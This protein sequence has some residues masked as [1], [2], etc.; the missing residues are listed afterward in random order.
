MKSLLLLIVALTWLAIFSN[1][2]SACQCR[3]YDVP[4]C[5]AYWT[6]STVFVGQL[7][8]ITLPASPKSR[9]DWP[10]ATLH[11]IVEQPFRGVK[12]P[13][14]DV[15]TSYGAMCDHKFVKGTRYLVYADEDSTS[16]KLYTGF[17]DRTRELDDASDDISYIRSVMQQSATESIVGI[18]THWKY[19][20]FAGVK[21]EVRNDSKTLEA[22]TD[23]KGNFWISPDGPG[24]FTCESW[25]RL[26]SW[27][28]RLPMIPSKLSNPRMS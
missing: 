7:R 28:C 8:D 14:V 17:C 11:F 9:E 13:T 15:E 27:L 16:H 3:D 18:V 5:A 20:R 12:G 21:I 1:S 26:L 23:E 22:T 19:E 2:A 10:M 6:T 24:T 4:V 25:R